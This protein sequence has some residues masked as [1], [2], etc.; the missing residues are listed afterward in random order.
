ME[1]S[2]FIDTLE[3]YQKAG[4]LIFHDKIQQSSI[5]F[6]RF[7][8]GKRSNQSDNKNI[9]VGIV[10][11][12]NLVLSWDIVTNNQ[13]NKQSG[14]ISIAV[15]VETSSTSIKY[16]ITNLISLKFTLFSI[17]LLFSSAPLLKR[18]FAKST[19]IFAFVLFALLLFIFPFSLMFFLARLLVWLE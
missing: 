1:Q 4:E 10:K 5:N 7:S 11:S 3:T 2:K 17:C 16:P 12:H 18:F 13:S 19:K 8:I 6:T 15:A 14:I 9:V